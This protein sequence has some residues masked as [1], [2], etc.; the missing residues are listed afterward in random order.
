MTK[1]CSNVAEAVT[2]WVER[3]SPYVIEKMARLEY[4]MVRSGCDLTRKG[5]VMLDDLIDTTLGRLR[6]RY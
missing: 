2:R 1:I 5:A 3:N 6:V 4:A